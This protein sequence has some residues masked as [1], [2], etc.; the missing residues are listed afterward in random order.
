MSSNSTTNKDKILCRFCYNAGRPKDEYTGHYIMSLPNRL[1]G[2]DRIITCPLLLTTTC[3]YCHKLG[4]KNGI[5]C[6]SLTAKKIRDNKAQKNAIFSENMIV[7]VKGEALTRTNVNKFVALEENDRFHEPKISKTKTK[8]W[9]SIV[10]NTVNNSVNNTVNCVPKISKTKPLI[11]TPP[12]PILRR[13]IATNFEYDPYLD[14]DIDIDSI[15]IPPSLY[16][17]GDF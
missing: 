7:K 12:I 13:D 1:S 8:T 14:Y 11:K 6:P 2:N 5:Y 3:T 10:N 4:H 15:H 16:Y 17:S 9:A